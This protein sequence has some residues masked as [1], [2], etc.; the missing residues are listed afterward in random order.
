MAEQQID[1]L[2]VKLTGDGTE[3]IKVLNEGEKKTARSVRFFEGQAAKS[4]AAQKASFLEAAA[5]TKSVATPTETYNRKL[6]HLRKLQNMG[7]LSAETMARST[8]K[9]KKDMKEAA[10]T[11]DTQANRIKAIGNQMQSF[12]KKVSLFVTAPIAAMAA[13]S[14]RSFSKFDNA[15]A[16]STAIMTGL[17]EETK[18]QM[19]DVA[20][21]LSATA[22]TGPAELAKSFF[23]LASAGLNAAQSIKALP[24]VE[25]FATAGAFDMADATSLLSDSQKALGLGSK[26]AAKNLINLTRVSDV[27]IKANVLANASTRQFAE[28]LTT[29]AA[30]ALRN[31]KKPIEEGVAVL[32]VFANQ[33]I[34]GQ[35]AGEKLSIVLRDLQRSVRKNKEEWIKQGLS[36][37]DSQGKMLK[38][39]AIIKQFEGKLK[40]MSD[41][42]KGATLAQLGF[43]DRSVS[44]LKAL[45]GFS[46]QIEE[47]EKQL[48]AAG[49]TTKKVAEEQMKSFAKQ[50][51]VAKNQVTVLAIQ[52]GKQL[53]PFV[54]SL[55]NSLK[56]TVAWFSSLSDGTKRALAIFAGLVA[57]VGPL[58]AFFGSATV[59]IG[60]YTAA[61]T[62]AAAAT[63][64][65]AVAVTALKFAMTGLGIGAIAVAMVAAADA[66]GLFGKAAES[67]AEAQNRLNNAVDR[68]AG[69]QRSVIESTTTQKELDTQEARLKR[70]LSELDRRSI[71]A[72]KQLTSSQGTLDS[73]TGFIVGT[74]KN[75]KGKREVVGRFTLQAEV[76]GAKS[77]I[78]IVKKETNAVL[79]ALDLV[80]SKRA[81]LKKESD[82]SGSRSPIQLSQSTKDAVTLTNAL[83]KQAKE[84]QAQIAVGEEAGSALEIY[85]LKQQ[86]ASEA[87]LF[88]ARVAAR[89]VDKLNKQKQAVLE[90]A[91]ANKKLADD[92][93]T[94]SK[95]LKDQVKFFGLSGRA[96]TIKKL[97]ARQKELEK[98]D[99]N[100]PEL[101]R[102]ELNLIA[103][104]KASKQLDVLEARKK[105]EEAGRATTEKFLAP[106]VKF[107]REQKAL[108]KQ[109][110]AGVISQETFAKANADLNRRFGTKLSRRGPEVNTQTN[111]AVKLGSAEGLAAVAEVFRGSAAKG[112]QEKIGKNTADLVL[113]AKATNMQLSDVNDSLAEKPQVVEAPTG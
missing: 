94:L 55:A 87:T 110:D 15:M 47:Y 112:V 51:T 66:M 100:N 37:F 80:K 35:R 64:A 20:L 52:I 29:K 76:A 71:A 10:K 97:E 81:S 30:N 109:L 45:L 63:G 111:T 34:K 57:V 44:A 39:S 7:A 89:A 106:I 49:G 102:T 65:T 83:R 11:A 14:L 90:L 36:I 82:S 13:V 54:E 23:F 73:T 95:S 93:E 85:K 41:E 101:I 72:K 42:T 69:V 77:E 104:R 70:R 46:G 59:A 48:N 6:A 28:A 58:I 17:G 22:A 38:I 12:G 18:K 25:Q 96:L 105:L 75:K 108:K 9:L 19:A 84:L 91:A 60:A 107:Q 74:R 113:I 1:E 99:K 32:A 43:Q 78:A 86:G 50:L 88:E 53:A 92:T 68:A 103:A 40:G 21:S 2:K 16:E 26:D 5:I 27:L 56:N 67:A 98:K 24:A 79:A 4:L 8:R 31:L 62:A 33:G 3:L 61:Q